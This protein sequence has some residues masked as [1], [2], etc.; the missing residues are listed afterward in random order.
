MATLTPKQC[1]S[2]SD[3]LVGA[4]ADRPSLAS[5][6]SHAAQ[7]QHVRRPSQ[8]LGMPVGLR[9]PDVPRQSF[10]FLAKP[11]AHGLSRFTERKSALVQSVWPEPPR[12][13]QLFALSPP[14]A[15][16]R[17]ASDFDRSR[18]TR[19]SVTSLSPCRWRLLG[20][21]CASLLTDLGSACT[22]TQKP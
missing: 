1:L 22:G 3:K 7:P 8:L 9:K 21:R 12:S 18:S 6:E 11:S 19:S 14:T 13:H 15:P 17:G 5:P 2:D 16:V 20:R 10:S 4:S